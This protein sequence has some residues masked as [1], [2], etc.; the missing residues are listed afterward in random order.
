MADIEL[1]PMPEGEDKTGF[2]AAVYTA[3]YREVYDSVIEPSERERLRKL[4]DS[5][6]RRKNH[7]KSS[8]WQSQLVHSLVQRIMNLRMMV[9]RVNTRLKAPIAEQSLSEKLRALASKLCQAHPGISTDTGIFGGIPH[10]ENVRLSVGDILAKLYVYGD[11]QKVQEIYSDVSAEQ[12]KEALAYAQDFLEIA[13]DPESLES[14][15]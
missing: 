3:V 4:E 8:T 2:N 12:I 6:A 10:I 14:D 11:I 9:A 15:D 5:P 7:A 1:L 13:C